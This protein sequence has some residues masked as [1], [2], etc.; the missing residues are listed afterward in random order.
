MPRDGITTSNHTPRNLGPS[1]ALRR[2]VRLS[3]VVRPDK[4][5]SNTRS[6]LSHP[7][8]QAL[9]RKKMKTLTSSGTMTRM[10]MQRPRNSRPNAWLRTLR[11]R[12]RSPK[13]S[14]SP[15]SRSRS[16]HGM[17]RRTWLRSRTPCVVSRWTALSGARVHLWRSG[18]VSRSC[19][20]LLLLVGLRGSIAV[21]GVD[22]FRL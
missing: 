17:T 16:N 6:D 22:P 12:L 3:L 18:M 2:V 8:V 4:L 1:L 5:L 15:W 11:K 14:P 20:S 7:S 21:A 10:R 9:L 13:L 19:K